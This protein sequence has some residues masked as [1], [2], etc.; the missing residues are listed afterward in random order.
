M[1]SDIKNFINDPVPNFYFGVMFM[2]SLTSGSATARM[3]AATGMIAQMDPVASA[4]T[5][6]SNLT[7]SIAT[8]PKAEIGNSIAIPFP[9]NFNSESLTL[10]RYVRPRHVVGSGIADPLTG[11]CVQTF[12]ASKKWQKSIKLKD[13]IITVLHPQFRN[14]P[15][16]GSVPVPVAGYLVFDAYPTKW[17]MD[18]LNSTS[19]EALQETFEFAYRDIQRINIPLPF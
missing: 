11:W 10:K 1:L 18:A 7:M 9:K 13:I 6:V 17:D 3:A 14:V 4:F 15:L 19:N 16:L 5:E 8:E 12:E 2:E